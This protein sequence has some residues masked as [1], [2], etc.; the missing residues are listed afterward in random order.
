MSSSQDIKT[1]PNSNGSGSTP[2]SLGMQGA[3]LAHSLRQL[4]L[5]G[6][7]FTV[8]DTPGGV[9][10]KVSHL[11]TAISRNGKMVFDGVKGNAPAAAKATPAKPQY[12]IRQVEAGPI[13]PGNKTMERLF[14]DGWE[15]VQSVDMHG[16][17][18]GVPVWTHTIRRE[19]VQL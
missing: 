14:A 4:E 19:V 2:Q 17:S 11:H 16:K 6:Y 12:E 15:L 13:G 10:I 5:A 8:E 3:V 1:T 7:P 18:N 9:V